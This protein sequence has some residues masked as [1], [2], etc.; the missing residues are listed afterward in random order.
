ML[1]EKHG[2][3]FKHILFQIWTGFWGS[4]SFRLPEFIDK[5]HR[6]VVGFQ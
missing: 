4:R 2:V 6:K 3:L 5:R 1:S